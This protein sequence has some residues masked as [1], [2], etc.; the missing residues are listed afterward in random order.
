VSI[1]VRPECL[2]KGYGTALLRQAV[3][4][5]RS[6]GYERIYVWT[7]EKNHIARAFYEREGFAHK[8]NTVEIEIGGE[9]FVEL[10]YEIDFRAEDAEDD[11]YDVPGLAQL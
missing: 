10:R 8:G 5:L 4:E 7:L 6:R 1:Y 3:S 2:G 9:K 11:E